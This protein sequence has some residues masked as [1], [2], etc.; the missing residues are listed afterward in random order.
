MPTVWVEGWDREDNYLSDSAYMREGET[1]EQAIERVKDRNGI[2][3]VGSV[4]VTGG[5]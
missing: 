4:E 3:E 2:I 1:E 5:Q